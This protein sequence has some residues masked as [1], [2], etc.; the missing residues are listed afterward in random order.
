M[1]QKPR[2]VKIR[3]E[4]KENHT[5]NARHLSNL[6]RSSQVNHIAVR[7]DRNGGVFFNKT[8]GVE[9]DGDRRA[10]GAGAAV[11]GDVINAVMGRGGLEGVEE[12]D[13]FPGSVR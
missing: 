3:K 13:C 11:D 2:R 7:H 5:I 12:V 1:G 6:L 4:G 10:L 9:I 8:D